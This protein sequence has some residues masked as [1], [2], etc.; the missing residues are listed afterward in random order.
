MEEQMEHTEDADL[1]YHVI[2][3]MDMLLAFRRCANGEDPDMV[4]MELWANSDH[5]PMEDDKL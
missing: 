5:F 4:Y 3:G 2:S 1:G